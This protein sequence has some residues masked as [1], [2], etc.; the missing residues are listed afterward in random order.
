VAYYREGARLRPDQADTC[1]NLAWILASNPDPELRN[2]AEAV[3]WA[4]VACG[5]TSYT[6]T[7]FVGTLAAAYAEA[8]RFQDAVAA[9]E[10]A[11]NL[12]TAAGDRELARRNQELLTLYREGKAYRE[13]AALPGG[14]K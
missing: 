3:G 11:V 8:G 12:A 9:A 5:L 13:P 1:N 10:K 7:V 14:V 6:Q 2:G 4:E